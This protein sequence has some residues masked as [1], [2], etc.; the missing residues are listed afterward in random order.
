[1]T[2]RT[3]RLDNQQRLLGRSLAHGANAMEVAA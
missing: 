3:T 1:V 2:L